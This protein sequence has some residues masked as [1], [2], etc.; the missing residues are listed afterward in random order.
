M[1]NLLLKL[2]DSAISVLPITAIVLLLGIFVVKL[3]ID[4]ILTF[5]FGAFLLIIGMGLFS[6]GADTAIVNIGANIGASLTKKRSLARIIIICFTIGLIVTV[7]EP[8]LLVLAEQ[9]SN[10]LNKYLLILCVAIGVGIFLTLAILKTIFQISLQKLL[11][12]AYS[13]VFILGIFVPKEFFPLAFDGGGVTTGPMTVPFIMALGIGFASTISSNRPDDNFGLVSLCTV[14]PIISIL[15]MGI[16]ADVSALQSQAV[17]QAPALQGGLIGKFFVAM[18]SYIFDVTLALL[19]IIIFFLIYNFAVLHLPKK[20]IIKTMFGVFYVFVGLTLFLTGVNVGFA[21]VGKILGSKIISSPYS[22][23][24]IPVGALIGFFIVVAEPA[25]H[26]L[27]EQVEQ[28]SNGLIKKKQ[29]MLSLMFGVS[30]AVALSML[31]IVASLSIWWFI[32]PGYAVAF[33]LSLFTPKIYSAIAF[34]SGGVA[35]GPMTAT[36]LLPFALGVCSAKQGN[37]FT[38]AF[39]I[40]ALVAMTPVVTIQILGLVA[41]IKQKKHIKQLEFEAVKQNASEQ[42]SMVVF[43]ALSKTNRKKRKNIQVASIQKNETLQTQTQPSDNAD[44]IKIEQPTLIE[45]EQTINNVDAKEAT[46]QK[47]NINQ[48]TVQS[49]DLATINLNTLKEVATITVENATKEND[50]HTN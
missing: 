19:P 7:A 25:V 28:I 42:D 8:D 31:R 43:D 12:V 1:K 24:I 48:D 16:F 26:V 41:T 2:K 30:L 13:I 5:C 35:S 34:D 39:G 22:W 18:P 17:T 50:E 33:I 10:S 20:Y 6:L 4:S 44:I 23:L 49:V 45:V 37:I 15:L 47:D 3:D 21:A 27:N 46:T 40:V 11:F 32:L 36:F 9:L 14:G 29:M 38:D